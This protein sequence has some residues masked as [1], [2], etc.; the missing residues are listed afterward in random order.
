MRILRR[1]K[2]TTI[3]IFV[4]LSFGIGALA[5]AS[6]VYLAVL[7]ESI[8]TPHPEE[9]VQMAGAS[10]PPDS[11]D[12]LAY[13]GDSRTVSDL[14]VYGQGAISVMVNGDSSRLVNAATVS[15]SFFPL[16]RVHP[17]LGRPL[18]EQDEAPVRS[19]AVVISDL[20]ARQLYGSSQLALG[21]SLKVEETTYTIAGVMPLGFRFPGQ[22]DLWFPRPVN[23][24]IRDTS[25]LPYPL[26]VI[27]RLHEATLGDA[28]REWKVMYEARASRRTARQA[29][30]GDAVVVR[31]WRDVLI[32]GFRPALT[33]CGIATGV[34]WLAVLFNSALLFSLG[35]MRRSSESAI[36]LALGA[37]PVSLALRSVRETVLLC[38]GA[39]IVA[40]PGVWFFMRYLYLDGPQALT[41]IVDLQPRFA[42]MVFLV[43]VATTATATLNATLAVVR[44]YRAR[45]ATSTA[46]MIGFARRAQ[47][48]RL[49]SV[50]LSIQVAAT[51]VLLAGA[52]AASSAIVQ[53][54]REALGFDP[55]S[56]ITFRYLLPAKRYAYA[57]HR[58]ADYAGRLIPLLRQVPGVQF[59]GIA[60]ALP[61]TGNHA[62]YSID[63]NG[64]VGIGPAMAV[65]VS[66]DYLQAL[67]VGL[68]EGRLLSDLDTSTAIKSVVVS[69]SFAA[70]YLVGSSP[71]GQTITLEGETSRLIVGVIDDVLYESTAGEQLPQVYI[72]MQQAVNAPIYA[73]SVV[74]R[75]S[76][77]FDGSLLNE[78]ERAFHRLDPSIPIQ[79]EASLSE[80]LRRSRSIATLRG[81]ATDTLGMLALLTVFVSL[82]SIVAYISASR[83]RELCIRL[84]LG[85]SKSE[86]VL[87]FFKQVG[88]ATVAGSVLGLIASVLLDR[89]LM[90]YLLVDKPTNPLLLG[91]IGVVVLALAAG[92]SSIQIL[93]FTSRISLS[94]LQTE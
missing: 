64:V 16:L 84:A 47:G 70:K 65:Q 67:G 79:D 88:L 26:T 80:L 13:W 8:P 62:S 34:L 3:L 35:E 21:R 32:R 11:Q 71:I 31:L 50:L 81:V 52:A 49:L 85:A 37:K 12:L 86:L 72:P 33:A 7:S 51:M 17:E 42:Q 78:T 53:S 55:A 59:V 61:L 10:Y 89:I 9:I 28:Q 68:R 43:F 20:L 44:G 75:L 66:G 69:K 91:A 18:V 60:G 27:G 46:N 82:F 29:R 19:T 58:P 54:S 73:Q 2:A 38:A 94:E 1:C 24:Q 77:G 83:R 25:G 39:G 74:I 63:V 56:S 5:V 57:G 15:A 6:L 93:S 30:M 45:Y 87:P 22:T 90:H 76:P 36:R 14:S 92:L 41:R 23:G 40:I 4:V 48:V